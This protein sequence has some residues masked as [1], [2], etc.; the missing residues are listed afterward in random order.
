MGI[1]LALDE[2]QQLLQRAAHDLFRARCTPEAVRDIEA[3]DVGY[4][5]A[6]WREMAGLGWL[7]ITF[8]EAYGGSGGRFLDLY[9][10]YEEMGRFLVP[11]PHL[12]TVAV[13]GDVVLR[14]GS[15]AQREALLPAIAQGRCI[16]SLAALEADGGFGPRSVALPAARV[17]DGYLLT[18]TKLLVAYAAS[19]DWFLVPVRT[20]DAPDGRPDD[21]ISVL[22]VDARS[23]GTT[24]APVRNIAGQPLFAVT[25]DRVPVPADALVGPA[26]GGWAAL[27]SALTKA[28]VLQTAMIVGAARRVLEMTNQYAKDREQFGSPIGRYQA[29]QYLVTDIL[30]DLHRA[31]LLARQAAFR[32][33]AGRSFER[34]AA[35]AVAFGKRAAAHLHRQAHEVHAGV[36]FIVEHDLTLYSR[37]AKYWENNLG[38]ARYFEDLLVGAMGI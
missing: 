5:P 2:H 4:Q 19:A 25:F 22:L 18:G 13:A 17:A 23:P 16:V 21:G 1:D 37:R 36:A 12:D 33:D 3:G 26:D 28:A 32:I 6:L 20:G 30:I 15:E 14:A 29:V 31:D 24:L 9:P 11:S 27:S 7:G 38:D 8:P 35:I 10:L 34:E